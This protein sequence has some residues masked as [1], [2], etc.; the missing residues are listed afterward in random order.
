MIIS[1]YN[2][3]IGTLIGDGHIQKVQSST[4]KCRL[5]ISH[6]YQQKDYVDW[7]YSF[8]ESECPQPPVFNTKKPEVT[9]YTAY[10]EEMAMYHQMFYREYKGKYHK[11]LP[12]NLMIDTVALA[13]LYMDDGTK[14]LDCDQCRLATHNYSLDE[15]KKLQQ[16]FID[17]FQLP[18][19]IVKAG[20]SKLYKHQ[21]Y[22]LVFSAKHFHILYSLIGDFIKVQV[23]SM[24]YKIKPR[25]D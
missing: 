12:D 17:N 6:G 4:G 5:R 18:S 21:W 19:H 3:L 1:K 8:F 24:Y 16:L 25:N 13:V 9:F 22:Q 20:R 15:I 7:K 2:V 11:F 23:P 14:R 10:S